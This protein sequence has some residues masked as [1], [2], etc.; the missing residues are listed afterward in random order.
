M[1][2]SINVDGRGE[3]PSIP[4]AE[5]ETQSKSQPPSVLPQTANGPQ[6]QG[7]SLKDRMAA[8]KNLE[9]VANSI[10]QKPAGNKLNDDINQVRGNLMLKKCH[11]VVTDYQTNP[12][13]KPAG[14]VLIRL[15]GV[16]D[17]IQLIPP[18]HDALKKHNLSGEK[19]ITELKQQISSYQNGNVLRTSAEEFQNQLAGLK[20][21]WQAESK[22]NPSESDMDAIWEKLLKQPLEVQIDDA[23]K[24]IKFVAMTEEQPISKPVQV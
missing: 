22:Q 23:G 14:K 21:Q 12:D 1:S 3:I 10:N 18:D 11:Q 13:I 2:G 6:T 24:R 17:W 4:S 8:K 16:E 15:E 19:L 9:N 7:K 20:S 5:P